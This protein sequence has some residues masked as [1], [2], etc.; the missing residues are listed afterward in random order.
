[1]A[2]REEMLSAEKTLFD[3]KGLLVKLLLRAVSHTHTH[4]ADKNKNK[5]RR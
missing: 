2:I 5:T 1:M 4:G 3:S